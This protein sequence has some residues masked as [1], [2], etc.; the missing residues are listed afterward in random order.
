MKNDYRHCFDL[1]GHI[2]GYTIWFSAVSVVQHPALGVVVHVLWSLER[3]GVVP[4]KARPTPAKHRCGTLVQRLLGRGSWSC[5][6]KGLI[7]N[8]LIII[9]IIIFIC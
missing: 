4:A 8:Y 6:L 2:A 1:I 7:V 5:G 9:N 3:S